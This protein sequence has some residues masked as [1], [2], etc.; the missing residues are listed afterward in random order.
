[1]ISGLPNVDL[2]VHFLTADQKAEKRK[3]KW[4][5]LRREHEKEVDAATATHHDELDLVCSAYRALRGKPV[6]TRRKSRTAEE[7]GANHGPVVVAVLAGRGR[8]PSSL[9]A[10]CHATGVSIC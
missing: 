5:R 4:E 6:S 1:M 9:T 2:T 7:K 3:R 10:S 8:F